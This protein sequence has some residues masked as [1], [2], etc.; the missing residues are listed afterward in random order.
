M[1]IPRDVPKSLKLHSYLHISDSLFAYSNFFS[2]AADPNVFKKEPPN[3][4]VVV[5]GINSS[6]VSLAWEYSPVDGDKLVAIRINRLNSSNGDPAL[7]AS[8]L[9]SDP[10]GEVAD[11]FKK[12]GKFAYENPA[13][14]VINNVTVEDEFI[15]RCDALTSNNLN[16]YK[17]AVRLNV[18]SKSYS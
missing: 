18:Y 13:T 8:K 17:S 14:L 3:P 7:V 12:N 1:G 4:T 10:I 15:Y 5:L 11:A 2:T 6:R 9:D 16:G